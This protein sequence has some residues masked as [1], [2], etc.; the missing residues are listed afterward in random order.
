MTCHQY[1]IVW[2]VRFYTW[3]AN[4]IQTSISITLSFSLYFIS[5]SFYFIQSGA[6]VHTGQPNQQNDEPTVQAV[7]TPNE[8]NL[9]I[10]IDFSL[11][12]S[13]CRFLLHSEWGGIATI[14]INE[15]SHTISS[16][17]F[18]TPF[19][20]FCKYDV[21]SFLVLEMISHSSLSHF[22]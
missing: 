2:Y 10:C 3:N 14:P 6:Q 15:L 17:H 20:Q 22:I 21:N 8:S 4:L 19:T 13:L 18:K 5:F 9:Q 1:Q 16:H 12:L 11:I 7:W